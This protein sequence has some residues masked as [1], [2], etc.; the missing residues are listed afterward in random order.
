MVFKVV[1]Y[2]E[3]LNNGWRLASVSD[4]QRNMNKV[5][6]I[7]RTQAKWLICKL[8]DGAITGWGYGYEFTQTY[9]GGYGHKLIVASG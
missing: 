1:T 3:Q 4:V 7:L 5:K 8:A 2:D 9:Q 6:D